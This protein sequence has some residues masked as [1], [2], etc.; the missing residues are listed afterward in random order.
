MDFATGFIPL[1]VAVA[2]LNGD[3]RSD[4]VTTN[5]GP[6]TVS[7][8]LGNGDGTFGRRPTRDGSDPRSVAVGDIDMDGLLDLAV[9]NLNSN[10]VSVLLGNGDGT[11]LAKRDFNSGA[12]A[13]H[14]VAIADF[15]SDGRR[16]SPC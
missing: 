14:S 2:D 10:T 1:S 11:F 5:R 16:T 3:G 4:L 9:T 8:L 13:T 7:V 6:N 15:N 12:N